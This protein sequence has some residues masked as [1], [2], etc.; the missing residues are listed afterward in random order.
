M[1]TAN[2]HVWHVWHCCHGCGATRT[3][4]AAI[5]AHEQ[6]CPQRERTAP[7]FPQDR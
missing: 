5:H 4:S 1:T 6:S 2:P 3:T 7:P